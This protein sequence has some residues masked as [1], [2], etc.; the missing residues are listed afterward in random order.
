[1]NHIKKSVAVQV[2]LPVAILKEGNYFIAHSPVLDLSTSGKSF[3]Q[4]KRRFNEAV[5]IFFEEL[6]A[7]GTLDEVLTD[8]GWYKVQS[9]WTPPVVISQASESF[10][11]PLTA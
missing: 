10:K 5:D 11:I 1:M 9:K 7:K 2:S 3:E 6:I 4:V 8:L